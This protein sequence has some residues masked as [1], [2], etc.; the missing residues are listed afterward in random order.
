MTDGHNPYK[1]PGPPEIVQAELVTIPMLPPNDTVE[2]IQLRY[3]IA[4]LLFHLYV[5]RRVIWILFSFQVGSA[6]A[7]PSLYL[8]AQLFVIPLLIFWMFSLGV[9]ADVLLF[10]LRART[11]Y[12]KEIEVEFGDATFCWT[13]VRKYHDR[14]INALDRRSQ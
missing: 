11:P 3:T 12:V 1:S 2:D 13:V 10:D 4:T 9:R 7:L 6:L 5:V 14:L 8:A